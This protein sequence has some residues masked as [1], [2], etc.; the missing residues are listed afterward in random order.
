[1]EPKIV[2][3]EE[4]QLRDVV[5]SPLSKGPYIDATVIKID[6]DNKMVHLL[7]PRVVCGDFSYTGGV[8]H[9]LGFEQYQ[10]WFNTEM[11]LLDRPNDKTPIR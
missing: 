5:R 2:K 1:M 4:L 8:L 11:E 9:S 7:R 10:I 3:G 6:P